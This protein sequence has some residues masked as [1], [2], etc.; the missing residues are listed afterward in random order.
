MGMA[1]PA[2]EQG[3]FAE[4]RKHGEQRW[5]RRRTERERRRSAVA[6]RAA[7]RGT[8]ADH[9]RVVTP[10]QATRSAPTLGQGLAQS[11]ES[12]PDANLP[13]G[14]HKEANVT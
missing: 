2:K 8:R 14:S 12:Q 6:V 10:M 11:S 7:V 5:R 1:R 4:P 9:M 3:R 13:V